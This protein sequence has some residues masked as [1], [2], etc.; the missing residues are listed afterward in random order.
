MENILS[1]GGFVFGIIWISFIVFK[2]WKLPEAGALA[3]LTGFC[4]I[5]HFSNKLAG[6]FG[7][8]S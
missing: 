7:N 5:H 3:S 2:T 1:V 4:A 8:K 6:A